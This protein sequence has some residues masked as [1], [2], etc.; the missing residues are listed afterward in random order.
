M[1]DFRVIAMGAYIM[2]VQNIQRFVWSRQP[3]TPESCCGERLELQAEL[4]SLCPDARGRASKPE[5][6][7]AGKPR[8]D[9]PAGPEHRAPHGRQT[10]DPKAILAG[11]ASAG[12]SP[13]AHR[14]RRKAGRE[15]LMR[16]G[17]VR[18]SPCRPAATINAP[19]QQAGHT[20]ALDP[21][22]GTGQENNPCRNGASTHNCPGLNSQRKRSRKFH[23]K[24]SFPA[25]PAQHAAF[26]DQC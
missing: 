25:P 22:L 17:P 23:V 3:P 10:L 21:M 26:N 24:H 9:P 20:K 12:I 19:H 8:G 15:T 16:Y 14:Q 1:M 18:A 5:E 7:R 2:A 4:G 11:R 13:Q 6:P